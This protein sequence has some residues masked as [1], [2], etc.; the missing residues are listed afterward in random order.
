MPLRN[1]SSRNGSLTPSWRGRSQTGFQTTFQTA[2]QSSFFGSFQEA[3]QGES[4]EGLLQPTHGATQI[5]TVD[6]FDGVFL[7]T[8]H[9]TTLVGF[10]V[11]F[12]GSFLNGSLGSFV[13]TSLSSFLGGCLGPCLETYR[14]GSFRAEFGIGLRCNHPIQKSVPGAPLEDGGCRYLSCPCFSS[15]C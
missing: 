2:F 9:E 7:E 11:G 14:R 15:R 6:G 8:F 1:R 12:V 13:E 10:H 4:L 5:P 3:F